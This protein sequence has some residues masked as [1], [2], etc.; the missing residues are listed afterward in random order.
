MLNGPDRTLN[1]ARQ[2]RKAMSIPEQIL[3][4]QLRQRPFGL[5]FRRQHPAGD[6]I[7]D[8][9]CH[10]ATLAIE[11]DDMSHDG[12]DA[13]R[14]DTAKRAWLRSQGVR[15]IRISAATVSCD[16]ASAVDHIVACALPR[17]PASSPSGEVAPEG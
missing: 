7:V 12:S 9:Y 16:V 13:E 14:R 1:R 6:Y 3:W 10:A 2:L 17:L 8:F 5:K 11:V 15:V 4:K